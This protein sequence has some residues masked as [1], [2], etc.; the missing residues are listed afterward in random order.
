[1]EDILT[2]ASV[3]RIRKCGIHTHFWWKNLLENDNFEEQIGN[4]GVIL[5]N[6]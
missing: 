6:T 1:M 4:D 2:A 5:R 3:A